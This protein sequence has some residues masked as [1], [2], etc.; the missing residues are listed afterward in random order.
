MN[1]AVMSEC[2]GLPA[3]YRIHPNGDVYSTKTETHKLLV[4]GIGGHGYPTVAIKFGQSS[5]SVCVHRL[6]A[7]AFIPNPHKKPQVNHIDGNKLN[8]AL[9]NLEWVT[10][11]ENKHHAYAN[12]LVRITASRRA[13]SR[14]NAKLMHAAR[15][16]FSAEDRERIKC[17]RANGET[18]RAI[19]ADFG[20]HHTTIRD[21]CIGLSYPDGRQDAA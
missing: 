8:Y 17:R 14:E 4:R 7:L 13:A 6:L 3:G 12:G 5:R 18:Y 21:V 2:V 20:C 9:S 19:A 1:E 16:I 15:R 10:D 11:S